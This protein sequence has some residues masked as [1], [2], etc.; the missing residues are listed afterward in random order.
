VWYS[1]KVQVYHFVAKSAPLSY[2]ALVLLICFVILAKFNLKMVLFFIS[3]SVK[4]LEVT[5]C[6]IFNVKEHFPYFFC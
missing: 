1:G 4:R 6:L 2:N 5:L 3:V